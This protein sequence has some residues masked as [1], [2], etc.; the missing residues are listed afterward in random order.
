MECS[1]K[2]FYSSPTP[3]VLLWRTAISC[4]WNP[5]IACFQNTAANQWKQFQVP[6]SYPP[7]QTPFDSSHSSAVLVGENCVTS[8]TSLKDVC[9][10]GLRHPI[11]SWLLIGPFVHLSLDNIHPTLTVCLLVH[12]P[13]LCLPCRLYFFSPNLLL[14]KWTIATSRPTDRALDYKISLHCRLMVSYLRTTGTVLFLTVSILF[15]LKC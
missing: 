9:V 7:T 13:F 6:G 10:R 4:L 14:S 11:H 1:C 2:V 5:T 8:V 12:R 3:L 15:V